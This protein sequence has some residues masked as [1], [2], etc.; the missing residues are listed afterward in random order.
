MEDEDR[1]KSY[2]RKNCYGG[3]VG[4]GEV[5]EQLDFS[6]ESGE[7]NKVGEAP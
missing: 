3:K 1:Y 4:F 6:H 7:R 5:V 2:S